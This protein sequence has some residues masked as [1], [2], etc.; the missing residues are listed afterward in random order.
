MKVFAKSGN[1]NVRVQPSTTS[2]VLMQITTELSVDATGQRMK[3]N[4]GFNWHEVKVGNALGYVREDVAVLVPASIK[5]SYNMVKP[6]AGPILSKFGNRLHPVTRQPDRFHNGVDIAAPV[7]RA[8]I[9]PADGV[10][11]NFFDHEHG[12][13]T[14]IIQHDN[15]LESRMAHLDTCLVKIGERVKQ[16]QQVATNGRTGR[17]TGP[18]LHYGIRNERKEFINPETIIQFG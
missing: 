14:L 16:A 13:L 6:M 9:S 5:P 7:G 8:I 3:D 10:V 1:V 11:V 17:V 18:H 2:R 15:G 12:G 4:Q